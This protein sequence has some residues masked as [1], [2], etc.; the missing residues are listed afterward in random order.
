MLDWF[1]ALS[2]QSL[3]S[4][5][6]WKL[7]SST[8]TKKDVV[9]SSCY[10]MKLWSCKANSGWL[11]NYLDELSG[12]LMMLFCH[13]CIYKGIQESVKK[14]FLFFLRNNARWCPHLPVFFTP[15]SPSMPPASRSQWKRVPAVLF[16]RGLP[17]LFE[18]EAIIHIWWCRQLNAKFGK[19][20]QMARSSLFSFV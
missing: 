8:L 13:F 20:Q 17:A 5:K 11:P 3:H 12:K 7:V 14:S 4:Q 6:T 10:L 15:C 2:S 16:P 9:I 1:F 18:S 19:S